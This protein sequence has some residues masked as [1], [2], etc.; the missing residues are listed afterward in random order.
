MHYSFNM[1]PDTGSW[2]DRPLE[3]GYLIRPASVKC[4]DGRLYVAGTFSTLASQPSDLLERFLELGADSDEAIA[5][6]ARAWGHLGMCKHG[7]PWIAH[8]VLHEGRPTCSPQRARRQAPDGGVLWVQETSAWRSLIGAFVA[9]IEIAD[10]LHANKP[11]PAEAWN[12]LADYYVKL[13]GPD[14]YL[15][16]FRFWSR[17][18]LHPDPREN[19]AVLGPLSVTEQRHNLARVLTFWADAAHVGL[20]VEWGSMFAPFV[21]ESQTPRLTLGSGSL[22]GALVV[23]LIEVC[24]G[25]RGLVKCSWCTAWYA[26]LDKN[27]KPRWPQ[28]GRRHFCPKCRADGVPVRLAQRDKR[29]GI[30]RLRQRKERSHGKAAHQKASPRKPRR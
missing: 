22:F 4:R 21:P 3:R 24:S 5:L 15:K 16:T 1:T 17:A 20:D 30:S 6:F 2:D 12:C 7:V 10:R 27:G 23:Q 19:D 26:P 9:T 8:W 25:A 29:A 14:W 11:A 13:F 18:S 28:A